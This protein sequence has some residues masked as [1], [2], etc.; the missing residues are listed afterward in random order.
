MF[1]FGHGRTSRGSFDSLTS[2]I[3]KF[4]LEKVLNDPQPVRLCLN[5]PRVH[6]MIS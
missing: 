5:D 3:S 4:S 6:F 1:M 2:N